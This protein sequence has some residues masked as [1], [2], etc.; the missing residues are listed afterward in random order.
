VAAFV[1]HVYDDLQQNRVF[2]QHRDFQLT[3]ESSGNPHI[4]A[5]KIDGLV[6]HALLSAEQ[7]VAKPPCLPW[8]ERLHKASAT[9]C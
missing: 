9:Y 8:S 2:A 1:E 4:L 5:N 7:K 6:T 3:L